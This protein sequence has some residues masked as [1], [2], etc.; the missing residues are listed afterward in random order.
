MDTFPPLVQSSL[1]KMDEEQRLTFQSEFDSRKKNKGA[2]IAC[3]IFLIHFF[4]Y[5]K[6]GMGII[7]VPICLFTGIGLVWWLIELFLIGKRLNEYNNKVAVDLARE[8]KLM[9]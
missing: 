2:M 7:Y 4:V 5:G 3:T 8:M 6:V 9:T 1:S